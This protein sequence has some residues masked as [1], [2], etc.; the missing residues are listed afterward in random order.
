MT[1]C[2]RSLVWVFV[3]VC[4]A[5][6]LPG[7][8]AAQ[9]PPPT[10]R[11]GE[12]DLARLSI[13]ELLNVEVT[14]VSRK[15]QRAD[16]APA[17][18]SVITREDIRRS[19]IRTLPELF[20]L[21]PG[22]QVAQVN[23]S[24]WA[25]SVRGFNDVYS[26]KLLVLIDGRSIYNRAFSGV[27]WNAEDL[28][29]DDID[30][31][32]V[33][34]GPG[35]AIWGANAVNGVINIVT[36]SAYETR[37]G[38]VRY[39]LGTFDRNEVSA[40]YGGALG[41]AAYRVFSQWSDHDET[42]TAPGIG[43]GDSNDVLTNGVRL[44]WQSGRRSVSFDGG[45]T[46]S[47]STPLFTVL[48][49]PVPEVPVETNGTAM[50]H[51]GFVLGRFSQTFANGSSLQLQSFVNHRM[52]DDPNDRSSENTEDVDVEYHVKA[53]PRQDVVIGGGVRH[54]VEA[55]KGTYNYTLVPATSRNAITNI[56]G[57]DEIAI[58]DR[59]RL[60]LGS[61]LEHDTVTGFG[62][63]PTARVGWDLVPGRQHVWGAISRA[64]R[65][66]SSIDLGAVVNYSATRAPDGTPV[67][68]QVQGN[69]AFRVEELV[70]TEIGYRAKLHATLDIDVTAFRGH[71]D[72]L[73]TYEPQAPSFTTQPLPHVIAPIRFAN[74][75]NAD[76]AGFETVAH[77]TP[78]RI[79]RLDASYSGFHIV[80]H[81]DPTSQDLT[82]LSR[83]G[84][85]PMHQWQLHSSWWLGA[86]AE[87]N[88]GLF[89]V[90]RL[91]YFDV[92]AYTRADLRLEVK[93][94]PSLSLIGVG[95]NLLTPSHVEYAPTEIG[96]LATR[97]PRSGGIH[98]VWR[99][100]A[101]S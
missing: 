27:F 24:N 67:V 44:D 4:P 48:T 7:L 91:R 10:Q 18:V 82:S 63:Q 13:E 56:F 66:P 35:G 98:V 77:W 88:A 87:L 78:M 75:A 93:L 19:G 52:V 15:E 22:V 36:K 16:T 65:T 14:S 96:M 69:P 6:A 100:G 60:T 17:A 90:G 84:N 8:L 53:G 1:K 86:R 12:A 42:L 5:L 50:R 70:D 49:L 20:R 61:K 80:S 76:S 38:L 83:D 37:G 101:G 26:N 51:T 47:D 71:Y 79:W 43:A 28:L 25:I 3:Y 41:S 59:L 95:Q 64:L 99:V 32:E 34:R 85:A 33:V 39:G 23:A 55:N 57:Q 89:H 74:L 40:R 46:V 94:S 31:I 29:I 21:V 92:P 11:S 2:L 81:V 68:V 30:R 62:V 45:F 72:H 58:T 97:I 54:T 9:T 73:R